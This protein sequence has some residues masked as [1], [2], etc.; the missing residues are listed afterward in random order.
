LAPFFS[1]FFADTKKLYTDDLVNAVVIA[2]EEGEGNSLDT[3][4]PRPPESAPRWH[5]AARARISPENLETFRCY[6]K[7][8]EY[9]E[10]RGRVR[11]FA[12]ASC[13]I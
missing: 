4:R 1:L 9:S 12:N 13:T 5:Y 10:F 11:L 2:G 7:K 3:F 8:T 6:E